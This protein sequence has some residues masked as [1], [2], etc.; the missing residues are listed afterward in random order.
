MLPTIWSEEPS[1]SFSLVLFTSQPQ[2]PPPPSSH[3][4]IHT[5]QSVHILHWREK[6]T[7]KMT[8]VPENSQR[9]GVKVRVGQ[10]SRREK[11]GRKE[12]G[13]EQESE[14]QKTRGKE[15]RKQVFF[16]LNKQNMW[17]ES[18][19]EFETSNEAKETWQMGLRSKSKIL[20]SILY[21]WLMKC[22]VVGF[23]PTL[24]AAGLFFSSHFCTF[25]FLKKRTCETCEHGATA[26]YQLGLWLSLIRI[27]SANC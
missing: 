27:V 22:L 17:T 21:H 10:R 23:M 24:M 26:P 3:S 6:S 11:V 2:Q 1:T 13:W 4:P 15:R 5:K 12:G 8:S 9:N 14:R 16:F 19:V 25:F 7:R 18:G 20:T